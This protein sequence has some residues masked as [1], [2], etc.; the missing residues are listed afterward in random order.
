MNIRVFVA[1]ALALAILAPAANALT[2]ANSEKTGITVKVTPKGAKEMD[3][4]I[5]AGAKAD[6]DCKMGCELMLGS[7]KVSVD[8]KIA[9]VTVKDGKFVM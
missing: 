8:G 9:T 6:V 7:Q 2:I 3:L 5:K 1:S 4:A